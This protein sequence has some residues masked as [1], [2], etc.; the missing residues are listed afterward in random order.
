MKRL[1]HVCNH[2]MCIYVCISIINLDLVL[3]F[4]L[5]VCVSVCVRACVLCVCLRVCVCVWVSAFFCLQYFWQA[6]PVASVSQTIVTATTLLQK[7][8]PPLG[9]AA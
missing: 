9:L 7:S 4:F 2:L 8:R 6:P 5:C 1:V 3:F